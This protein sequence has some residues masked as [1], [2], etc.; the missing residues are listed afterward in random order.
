M[1]YGVAHI[2]TRITVAF[3]KAVQYF[4]HLYGHGDLEYGGAH[5]ISPIVRE[6]KSSG[7]W[8]RRVP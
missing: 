3:T 6:A 4:V 5:S 8:K 7:N 1:T 2:I